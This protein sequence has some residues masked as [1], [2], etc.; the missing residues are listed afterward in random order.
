[1]NKVGDKNGRNNG[2]LLGLVREM[3]FL[4]KEVPEISV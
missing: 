1:M 4:Q 2:F 3:A